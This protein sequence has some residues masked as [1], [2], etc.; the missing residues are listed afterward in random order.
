MEL[1]CAMLDRGEDGEVVMQMLRD[2]CSTVAAL[3]CCISRVRTARLANAPL[4]PHVTET[5]RPY[6]EEAGVRAFLS[7]P[8]AEMLRVQRAHTSDPTWSEGAE[9]ALA[10][11]R[12]LPDNLRALKLSQSELVSLK[13]TR[14]GALIGKQE[15]LL[16]IHQAGDWLRYAIALAQ[17]S[18]GFSVPSV[19]TMFTPCMCCK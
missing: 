6:A 10:S 15:S 11:L 18:T 14:D 16:H 1:A 8:L 4:P 7:L 19:N 17:E 2:K 13:R 5:M 3:S 12:L 9:A